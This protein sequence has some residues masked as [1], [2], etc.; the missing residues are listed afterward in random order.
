MCEEE[1][2]EKLIRSRHSLRL[3]TCLQNHTPACQAG[4]LTRY[5]RSRIRG[6]VEVAIP[7]SGMLR[8]RDFVVF[9]FWNIHARF[10]EHGE[11]RA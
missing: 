6:P 8:L 5:T 10:L 3:L 9:F 7:S 2:G 11:R 1:K 4:F